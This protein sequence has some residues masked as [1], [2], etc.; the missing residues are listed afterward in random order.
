MSTKNKNRQKKTCQVAGHR[1]AD[2]DHLSPS[3]RSSCRHHSSLR[4][5][6]LL[7][8]PSASH[9]APPPPVLPPS[10]QNR[11]LPTKVHHRHAAFAEPSEQDPSHAC[12]GTARMPRRHRIRRL[13]TESPPDPTCRLRPS[14]S[15][16]R[17]RCHS[18]A[19]SS[20]RRPFSSSSHRRSSSSSSHHHPSHVAAAVAPP[21]R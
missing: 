20:R 3:V 12:L 8:R 19:S 13:I 17:R 6:A 21:P 18:S 2:D 14:S 16:S 9:H 5:P 11:C 10:P 1:A 4:P 15:S 7:L